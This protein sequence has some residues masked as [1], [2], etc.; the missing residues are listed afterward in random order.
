MRTFSALVVTAGL[1]LSLTACSGGPEPLF[2]GCTP[3]FESG[4][5]STQIDASGDFGSEPTVEFPTPLYSDEIQVT[6][7]EPGEGEP[8]YPGQ[9]VDFHLTAYFGESGELF[10][11]TFGG[12]SPIRRPIT[13]SAD[14]LGLMLQCATVGSRL[15]AVS[16]V[17]DI[18][19]ED[20]ITQ[21]GLD[22]DVDVVVVF[23]VIDGY[24]GKANGND[25]LP[26]AGFPAISLAPNGQ[27]GI[28][29][30]NEEPPTELKIDVLKAGDGPVVEEG[31]SV[32]LHYTG[33]VWGADNTFES[34]W[35]SGT[36]TTIPF[37]E[38]DQAAGEAGLEGF[39]EAV[40]GERVGS[41]VIVI[42]PPEFGYREGTGPAGVSDDSTLFFVIDI[43]GIEQ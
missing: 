33:L 10:T 41:Q 15:A 1:I 39:T 32:V 7:L 37:G 26:Q 19:P 9:V 18:L 27:P 16:T 36:P 3:E 40:L 34:T 28:T 2:G 8:L 5:A 11:T 30:L 14:K 17:G 23:D 6:E 42:I 21:N 25:Q 24:L 12:E 31:D 29:P 13:E 20:T 38:S 22:A 35:E 4:D 43:L